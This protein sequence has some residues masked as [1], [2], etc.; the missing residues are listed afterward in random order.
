MRNAERAIKALMDELGS[1]YDL[2]LHEC[3]AGFGHR[4]CGEA[5]SSRL[6]C[7]PTGNGDSRWTIVPWRR[8]TVRSLRQENSQ[9][10]KVRGL[11]DLGSC[12]QSS[13][14]L[15]PPRR[16]QRR[17]LLICK[18]PRPNQ[19]PH[20]LR[21]IQREHPTS[22]RHHIQNQLRMLP[23]LKLAAAHIKR[24]VLYR[25]QQHVAITNQKIPQRITHWRAAIAASAR[26]VKHQRPMLR[27][28]PLD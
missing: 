22:P 7:D 21:P 20:P 24:G 27:Q 5:G 6:G 9:G 23:V 11:R 28:Q 17:N 4:T 18:H 2:S 1:G 14:V 15:N 26:L 13:I 10:G 16:P 25:C 8:L 12:G 19:K 3:D